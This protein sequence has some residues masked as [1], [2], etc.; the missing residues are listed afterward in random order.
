MKGHF[1]V[2]LF[3]S[4]REAAQNKELQICLDTEKPTVAELRAVIYTASPK[5]AQS[6]AFIMVA[7]NRKVADDTIR[8]SPNDEIAL[9]PL[10]SGG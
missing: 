2:K 6:N 4:I 3:G 9:L 8:I 5:I 1:T 7:V 10:V